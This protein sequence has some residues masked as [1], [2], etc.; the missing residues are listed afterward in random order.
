MRKPCEYLPACKTCQLRKK[1]IGRAAGPYA[2]YCDRE[3]SGYYDDPQPSHYWSAEDERETRE[4][5]DL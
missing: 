3:C 2:H 1:P 5:L 4:W